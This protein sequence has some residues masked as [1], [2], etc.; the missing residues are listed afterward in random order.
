MRERIA[1]AMKD[2]LKSKDQATL[3]TIRLIVAAL[4]DRD[5]AARLDNNHDG[6]FD[7]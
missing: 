4:K 3:S 6:S 1:Q 7:S 2:A 5:I